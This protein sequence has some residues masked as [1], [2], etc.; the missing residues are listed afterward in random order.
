MKKIFAFLILMIAL[1]SCYDDYVKD[2][3]FNSVYFPN[4]ID[5][6]TVVVGEGLKVKI[7]AALG[8]VMD[9]K[10]DRNVNFILN[11]ALITPA[12]L[13]LMKT[14]SNTYIK[15]PTA[16]ITSL[17]PLPANYYTLSNT[18]TIVIKAGQHSGSV[19]LKVDSTA[20]LADAGTLLPQFVVPFYITT[21]DADTIIEPKRSAVI[22]IKYENMLFGNY[23]HG[24]ITTVKDGTGTIIQTLVYKTTTSQGDTKIWN[25]TTVGPNALVSNGYSDQTSTSK[26]ELRLTLN[27]TDITIS[28]ASGSTNT[29]LPDGASTYNNAKLLQDR[30]ILLNYKYVSGANTYYCQDT[31]TFRNR[32]RDGINEWQ[33]EDPSHYT[34]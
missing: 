1:V 11:N 30:K 20:F 23:L 3:D 10:T 5:V 2:F 16:T 22:G 15:N 31:L 25:L 12:V 33:D 34:K 8:G 14:S 13:T 18:G 19:T 4:T 27:G 6:R 28:N 17:L 29:Y 9:N 26:K 32:I 21:A 24:G 7:G